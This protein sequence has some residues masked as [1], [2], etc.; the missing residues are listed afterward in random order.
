MLQYFFITLDIKLDPLLVNNSYGT[1]I[2]A[3]NSIRQFSM[4]SAVTFLNAKASGH[5]V[6]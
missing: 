2:L 3:V 4:V 1:P 5:L 6:A